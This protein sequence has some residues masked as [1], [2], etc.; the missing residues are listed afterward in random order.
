MLAHSSGH[1]WWPSKALEWIQMGPRCPE[2]AQYPEWEYQAS[3]WPSVSRFHHCFS[4]SPA[5]HSCLNTQKTHGIWRLCHAQGLHNPSPCYNVLE[6][7][8]NRNRDGPELILLL[9]LVPIQVPWVGAM[10]TCVLTMSFSSHDGHQ[11]SYAKTLNRKHAPFLKIHTC[12][13]FWLWFSSRL[14]GELVR[15]SS[16]LTSHHLNF[17]N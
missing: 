3:E 5:P 13:I 11:I 10:D 17:K 2:K 14:E 8:P 4:V 7:S 15:W 6:D 1:S 12:Q 9:K 16:L